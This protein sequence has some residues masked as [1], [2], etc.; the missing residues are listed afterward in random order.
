MKRLLLGIMAVL[1]LVGCATTSQPKNAYMDEERKIQNL[2]GREAFIWI[3]ESWNVVKENDRL[4]ILDGEKVIMTQTALHPYTEVSDE[5]E[6]TPYV[7]GIQV[8]EMKDVV[9]TENGFKYGI[10]V[11][12]QGGEE[13][14]RY[15][16]HLGKGAESDFVFIVWDE[17]IG[18]ELVKEICLSLEAH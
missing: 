16:L 7:K 4:Y 8:K 18:E 3:P 9:E 13:K 6:N 14:E 2:S 15:F 5:V 1:M 10:Y 11:V 12:A 17:S